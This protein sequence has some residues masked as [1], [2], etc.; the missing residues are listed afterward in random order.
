MFRLSLPRAILAAILA[1]NLVGALVTAPTV[2][3][4]TAHAAPAQLADGNVPPVPVG[5]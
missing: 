5:H 4:L 3:R 2:L 1:V